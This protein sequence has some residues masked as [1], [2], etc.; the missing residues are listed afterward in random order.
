[1]IDI[2]EQDKILILD[3]GCGRKKIAGAVG[4][5]FS[6]M[7]DA[8]LVIDLNHEPLPYDD[9]SV[10]F[11]YSSHTLEHLSTKGFI[12]VMQEA[13]RVLR[14]GAQF[15]IVVPFFTTTV[16]LA[17]PFHNNNICFN[18]HTFRFFSSEPNCEALPKHEYETPSCPQWGLRYSANSEIGIE[19]KTLRIDKFYFP[20]Y[21]ERSA[22][23]RAAACSS[24]LNV[25][26]QISYSL[27]AVKPCPVRPETGPIATLDDPFLF[28]EDQLS[29]L[30]KQLSY[31][32]DHEIHSS[33][34]I[35]RGQLL[36]G[37]KKIGALYSSE[38]IL[39][40]VNFFIY[41]LDDVIQSLRRIIDNNQADISTKANNQ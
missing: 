22:P 32:K 13:Y 18:E 6:S 35:E 3:I 29:F 40:P 1:M 25:A 19:F 21:A 5:D 37:S 23:E 24:A 7:S 30:S 4:I 38:G 41:E 36:I 10:D 20:H 8:D 11:I 33:P 15:K 34:E 39:T 14:P 9:S 12:H 31:L 2:M 28:V 26:E 27:Q 17:N 16:N